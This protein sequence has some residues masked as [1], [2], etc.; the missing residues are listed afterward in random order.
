MIIASI[1]SASGDKVCALPSAA[2]SDALFTPVDMSKHLLSPTH[3]YQVTGV[4]VKL[5]SF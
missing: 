2:L 4:T 1:R 3:Y 5:N